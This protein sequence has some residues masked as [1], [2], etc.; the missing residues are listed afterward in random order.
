M[1]FKEIQSL[2]S[3]PYEIKGSKRLYHLALREEKPKPLAS[4]APGIEDEFMP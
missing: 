3:E 1:I 4:Y 2:M